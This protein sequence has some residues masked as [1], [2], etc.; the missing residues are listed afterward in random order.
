MF[1]A[2][3]G[4]G[5]QK[6]ADLGPF[7]CHNCVH[8]EQDGTC[9]EK[10]MVQLSAQKRKNGRPLVDKGDHCPYVERQEVRPV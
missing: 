5:F 2:D 6:A 8:M 9:S 7:N 10:H 1:N 3:N 4:T